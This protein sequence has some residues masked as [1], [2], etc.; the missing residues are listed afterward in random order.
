M[1]VLHVTR[2]SFLELAQSGIIARARASYARARKSNHPAEIAQDAWIWG[3][4]LVMVRWYFEWARQQKIPLNRFT[5]NPRLPVPEDKAAGRCPDLLYGFAWLDLTREPQLL[6][7]PDTNDRYY[8]VQM[9]DEYCNS[10]AYV[11]KRATGTKAASY[12]LVAPGWKGYLPSDV[13]KIQAPTN[14]VLALARTLVKGEEDLEAALAI[15]RQYSL[16]PL[17]RYPQDAPADWFLLPAIPIPDLRTLGITFFD[18]L[19][20]AL[21]TL[22]SAKQDLACLRRF[23]QLGI[24]GGE[25]P[26]RT[27]DYEV[28][29][30]LR[31]AVQAAT[32]RVRE[33]DY[34][35]LVNGW[36]VNL[37]LT[38]FIQDPVLKASVTLYGP[39]PN[40]A[41]EALYFVAKPT[42]QPLNGENQYVLSFPPGGL[43]PV[44]A[45][46]SLSAYSGAEFALMEN[47]MHRYAIGSCTSGLEYGPDGSL[48][49]FVQ[50]QIPKQGIRNWL[51]IHAGAF[52]LIL[53]AY[54]PQP[55]LLRGNYK[56]PPLRKI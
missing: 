20:V 2:H 16:L 34:S 26:S 29:S 43:P 21:A 24:A 3:S 41:D 53:R 36:S 49:I 25:R 17:H 30:G 4:P 6:C 12:A 1:S 45:F 37:H 46:W 55:A 15:Q 18:H 28:L 8:A 10:F 50:Q 47:P 44:D 33:A 38:G 48:D 11:G 52:H 14:R 13:K 22:P 51:P 32:D 39:G 42:E 56:L 35:R 9:I 5:G 31:E 23:A 19:A 7:V 40:I 54:Q 27:A